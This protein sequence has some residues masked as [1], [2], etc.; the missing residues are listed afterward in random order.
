MKYFSRGCCTS[1]NRNQPSQSEAFKPVPNLPFSYDVLLL[2]YYYH[3]FVCS[4]ITLCQRS[5]AKIQCQQDSLNF[6]NFPYNPSRINN[7]GF[8]QLSNSN[9]YPNLI[10]S[11]SYLFD[12]F[13]NAAIM[14]GITFT[15]IQHS[16]LSSLSRS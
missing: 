3:Y 9:F 13:L 11:F 15:F 5:F 8:L 6:K 14:M 12:V 7:D 16:F 1:A 4:T 10:D 2:Y